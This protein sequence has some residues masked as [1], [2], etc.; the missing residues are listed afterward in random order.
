MEEKKVLGRIWIDIDN[1]NF[2]G[3]GKI[4]LLKKIDEYGS[5]SKAAKDM[6]MSYKAAWDIVK[7]INTLAKSP[8]LET[9]IG[10]AGGGGS[11]LTQ[12]GKQLIAAFEAIEKDLDK[13]LKN[14]QNKINKL[15]Q[16]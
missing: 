13:F 12:K 16:D 6:K 3:K 1:K 15:L 10:G 5:I 11:V 4:E 9:K 14:A 2:L 7:E 8:I